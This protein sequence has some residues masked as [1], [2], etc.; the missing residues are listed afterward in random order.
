MKTDLLKPQ[1]AQMVH[2]ILYKGAIFILSAPL[3]SMRHVK[4]VWCNAIATNVMHILHAW[5]AGMAGV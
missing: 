3:D 2:L 1:L 4:T 5:I